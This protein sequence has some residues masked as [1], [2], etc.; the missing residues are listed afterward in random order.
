M[1]K[2][3]HCHTL[4]LVSAVY[5]GQIENECRSIQHLLELEESN[6]HILNCHLLQCVC[7]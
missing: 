6:M 7:L 2:E 1:Q 5:A 4:Y 3:D